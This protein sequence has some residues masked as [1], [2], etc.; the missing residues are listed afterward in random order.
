MSSNGLG[1]VLGAEDTVD[2]DMNECPKQVGTWKEGR[3]VLPGG[4]RQFS[5]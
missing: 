3:A 4:S 5:T 1:S 2:Y